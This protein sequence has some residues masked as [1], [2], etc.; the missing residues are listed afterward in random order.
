LRHEVRTQAL[1]DGGK[2]GK[3]LLPVPPEVFKA[4]VDRQ[5]PM[6]ADQFAEQAL[7]AVAKNRAIIVIPSWLRIVWWLYRLSPTLG[8]YLGRKMLEATKRTVERSPLQP[9]GA[10]GTTSPS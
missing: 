8:L 2:Y 3:I 1:I 9:T 4:I 5:H 6:Q 7:R 10:A